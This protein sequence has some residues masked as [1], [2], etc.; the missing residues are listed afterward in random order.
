MSKKKSHYLFRFQNLDIWKKEFGQFLNVSRRSTF[1]NANM[2][3]IYRMRDLIS[4][5][6]MHHLLT[7]LDELS[8]MI[9]GFTASALAIS[10]RRRSPPES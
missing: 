6:Q 2:T 3:M 4:E 9:S 8:R 10:V 5:E 7:E 1:E